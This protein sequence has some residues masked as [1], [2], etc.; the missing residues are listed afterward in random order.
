[1]VLVVVMMVSEGPGVLSREEAKI[2]LERLGM[3]TRN[4]LGVV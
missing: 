2:G 3:G 4:I 1:M